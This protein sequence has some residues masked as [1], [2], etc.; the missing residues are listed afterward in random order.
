MSISI[1]SDTGSSVK[2]PIALEIDRLMEGIDLESFMDPVSPQNKL[3]KHLFGHS[4]DLDLA[5]SY[6]LQDDG[7]IDRNPFRLTEDDPY[8]DYVHLK[9]DARNAFSSREILPEFA[10]QYV[11]Y[12]WDSTSEMDDFWFCR[13]IT[14]ALHDPTAS[15]V[16]RRIQQYFHQRLPSLLQEH[17]WEHQVPVHGF[18]LVTSVRS[19]RTSNLMHNHDEESEDLKDCLHCAIAARRSG[20]LGHTA[21]SDGSVGGIRFHVLLESVASTIDPN[22]WGFWTF[23]NRSADGSERQFRLE[24]SQQFSYTY[25]PGRSFEG[26]L[27]QLFSD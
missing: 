11:S 12:D 21:T 18:I 8:D 7:I 14:D 23:W 22:H 17:S 15:D 20:R 16:R 13:E 26:A 25:K 2:D 4:E 19:R 3:L 10:G 6:E 5:A 24:P 9:D 27:V 1:D